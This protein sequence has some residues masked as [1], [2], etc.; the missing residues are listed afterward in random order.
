M[1]NG[2]KFQSNQIVRYP[3]YLSNSDNPA[4]VLTSKPFNGS[5]Y[6]NWS[7]SARMH[8]GAKIKLGFIDGTLTKP[9]EDSANLQNWLTCDYMVTCWLLNSLIPEISECFMYAKSAKELWDELV[10]RFVEANDPLIYQLHRDL[11]LMMKDNE[12]EGMNSKILINYLNAH[13]VLWQIVNVVLETH[14]KKEILETSLFC[15]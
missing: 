6:I 9:G 14:C 3:Y 12:P 7:N 11:T 5:N 2:D 13:V 4:M 8:L 10:E 1:A 15:L